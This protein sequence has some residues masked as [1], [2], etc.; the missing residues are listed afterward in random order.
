MPALPAGYGPSVS[1]SRSITTPSGRR[2]QFGAPFFAR[3]LTPSELSGS[4]AAVCGILRS[5]GLPIYASVNELQPVPAANVPARIAQRFLGQPLDHEE[6]NTSDAYELV[7]SL[8]SGSG[9]GWP[10][11]IQ[12]GRDLKLLVQVLREATGGDAPIGMSLPL[13]AKAADLRR[14]VESQ[15]DYVRLLHSGESLV[16]M[17]GQIA[18][19]AAHGI[20]SAR[21]LCIQLGRPNCLCFSMHRSSAAIMQSSSWR[22]VPQP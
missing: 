8:P 17:S 16:S 21:R 4:W 11:E 20:V 5:K 19:L 13:N 14:C 15:V 2:L 7:N 3:G 1:T 12:S 18:N 6:V 10:Y 9:W 22:S